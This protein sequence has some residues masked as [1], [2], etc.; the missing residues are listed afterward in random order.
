MS[1][2]VAALDGPR[3]LIRWEVPP[4]QTTYSLA[5]LGAGCIA[6]GDCEGSITFYHLAAEG[7][8]MVPTRMQ[9]ADAW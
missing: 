3:R 5:A 6:A 4:R 7:R 8:C 9:L 1:A 2:G